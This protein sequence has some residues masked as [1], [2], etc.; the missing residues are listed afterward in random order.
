MRIGILTHV[1]HP[2]RQPFAGGLEAF[3]Y[4]ITLRLRE[5][6]HAVTLFASSA[7]APEL[8]VVV[9]YL[10]M[11]AVLLVRPQGLFGVVEARRV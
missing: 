11:V 8:E 1:K 2:V 5:R 4:D 7:S 10:I 9:P 6:G 3:T